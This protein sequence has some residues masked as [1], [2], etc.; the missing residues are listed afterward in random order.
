MCGKH[1]LAVS[2]SGNMTHSL[3]AGFAIMLTPAAVAT[4]CM[5]APVALVVPALRGLCFTQD[6]AA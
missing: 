6:V 2:V 4:A 1:N 3:V 5:P